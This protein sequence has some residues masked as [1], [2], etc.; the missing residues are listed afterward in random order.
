MTKF[1]I[2]PQDKEHLDA[3]NVGSL[4]STSL[5]SLQQWFRS[6]R[7]GA[8]FEYEWGRRRRS[9]HFCYYS[10]RR[11]IAASSCTYNSSYSYSANGCDDRMTL[12]CQLRFSCSLWICAAF[13]NIVNNLVIFLGK[14]TR[15]R[16]SVPIHL[17][18]MLH[19]HGEYVML[20]IGE[21]I[22]SMLMSPT[23][24]ASNTKDQL[25]TYFTCTMPLIFRQCLH[26][27]MKLK[28]L[29]CL[30]KQMPVPLLWRCYLNFLL[31]HMTRGILH[32]VR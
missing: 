32:R 15:S 5:L 18:Y 31:S 2:L 24:Y 12:P 9:Y 8:K 17:M 1:E 25:K 10:F 7:R 13:V 29:S 23:I 16:Q 22:F 19:R 6:C 11:R 3:S 28:L 21:S 20:L 30:L 27:K 14:L 26:R 4:A